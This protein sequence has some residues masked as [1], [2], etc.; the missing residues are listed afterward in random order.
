[1]STLFSNAVSPITAAVIL[2]AFVFILI[3]GFLVWYAL[4]RNDE[5]RAKFG[6]GKTIFEI[7]TKKHRD[8]P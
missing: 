4:R 8:A 7:E 1:V 2:L 3:T 6:H 5:V